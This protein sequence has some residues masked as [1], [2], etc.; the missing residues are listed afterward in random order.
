MEAGGTVD[1]T[2]TLTPLEPL[3]SVTVVD[4]LPQ[5]L[6]YVAGSATPD[7]AHDQMAGSLSW[8]LGPLSPAEPVAVRFQARWE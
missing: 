3:A 5:A 1:Y 8:R 6:A 7:A 2:I 4:S